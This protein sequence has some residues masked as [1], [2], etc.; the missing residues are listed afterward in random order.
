MKNITPEYNKTPK[1]EENKSVSEKKTIFFL[2]WFINNDKKENSKVPTTQKYWKKFIISCL[3]I[4]AYLP[5]LIINYNLLT[6][7]NYNITI[8]VYSQC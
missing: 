2:R 7:I 6:N 1:A 8:L 3:C 5:T 4:T